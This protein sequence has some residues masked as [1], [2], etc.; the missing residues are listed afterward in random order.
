MVPSGNPKALVPVNQIQ[1]VKQSHEAG[2]C[3][4][5][6]HQSAQDQQSKTRGIVSSR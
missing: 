5:Q 3:Q 2:K 1:A 6:H 4:Y